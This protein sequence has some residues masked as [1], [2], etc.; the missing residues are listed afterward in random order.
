MC[1][2]LFL[3]V[4]IIIILINNATPEPRKPKI[5]DLAPTIKVSH[6][7]CSEMT[8]NNLYSL[9]Q[10]KPCNMAPENVEVSQATI[11][12]YTKHFRT[13]INAT[14]CRIKHQRNRYYC[15]MHDHTSMDNEQEQITSDLDLTPEQCRTLAKGGELQFFK[16]EQK[17]SFDKGEKKI[18]LEVDGDA[19]DDN[20]NDCD[21]YEWITKDTFEGHVQDIEL[22]VRLKD[23]KVLSYLNLI[24]PCSLDELGC[25]STSL[26]PY[27]YTWDKQENCILSVLK[28]KETV[29]MLKNDNRYYI[30]SESTA[31]S[32]YLFEVKN[33]PLHLCNK[34]TLVYPTSYESLY[35]AIHS[36]GF[37]MTTGRNKNSAGPHLIHYQPNDVPQ[38]SKW[39]NPEHTG[40]LYLYGT[41]RTGT[42]DPY[43]N[44]WL[45]MDYEL[46][47]GTKLDYLFFESSRALRSSELNLLKNQC[48]QERIQIFTILMLSLENS[49]LAGYML[50]GNRSMFLETDGSL[51]WLYSCP[52]VLSPLHTMNQCYDKIPILYK[53]EIQFVD[54][55]TRQTLP[56]ALTQNC[57]DPIK[58]LFQMD[59]D[60]K[61]SWYSLTPQITHRD[62]PAI[63]APKDVSPFTNPQFPNSQKAGM[64]TRGQLS[65]F[66]DTI[67]MSSASKNA[68]QKF[69]RKL[70]VPLNTKSGNEKATFYAPRTDFFVD[71]MISPSFFENA[72]KDTFGEI[73]YFL[74][75]CGI[76]FATFLFIKLIID[77]VVSIIRTFEI[78]KITGRSVNF[79]KIILSATYNVFM[80]SILSSIYSPATK[81]EPQPSTPDSPQPQGQEMT[82]HIYPSIIRPLNN[83]VNTISPV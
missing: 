49:R 75:Q 54:P 21:G 4:A 81:V 26:D 6:Y 41:D 71:N 80:V 73:E 48:E 60:D 34:P 17:V 7:D 53:G 40:N 19:S 15:G 2:K 37:D 62:R 35:I 72:F 83:D 36:G 16:E 57:S 14:M 10:V 63:F 58:N 25:E 42:L 68:L 30:V 69:T 44:T 82:E 18:I 38:N 64:Y 29:K 45:N 28:G 74:Q 24:L 50:T 31:E 33:N 22:K 23:G 59:M 32:Q 8:E 66:W 77:I 61:D 56:D 12:L 43:D 47:M 79:G 78:H 51:A 55:I 9:N 76:W 5:E 11:S 20:R 65:E 3:F 27:A 70:I 39:F 67:L 52:H 46:H 13:T 1:Y